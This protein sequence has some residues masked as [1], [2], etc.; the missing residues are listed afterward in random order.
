VVN[1]SKRPTVIQTPLKTWAGLLRFSLLVLKIEHGVLPFL[2]Y[3]L[4]E[5]GDWHT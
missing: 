3:L 4:E 5:K 1:G 2:K